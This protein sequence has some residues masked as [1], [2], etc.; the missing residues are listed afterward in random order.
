MRGMNLSEGMRELQ[1]RSIN[2]FNVKC[3]F[4]CTHEVILNS[5][6]KLIEKNCE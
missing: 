6:D 5:L 4:V 1:G 3:T 2:C